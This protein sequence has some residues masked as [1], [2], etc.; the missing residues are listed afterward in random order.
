MSVSSIST[1]I[2]LVVRSPIPDRCLTLYAVSEA[3]N[4]VALSSK[5]N[6]HA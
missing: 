3:R 1:A 5:E 4:K 6:R 2:P